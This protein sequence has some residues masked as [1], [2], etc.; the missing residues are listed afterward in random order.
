MFDLPV[1]SVMVRR[2]TLKAPPATSIARAA[3]LMAGKNVGA[4]MVV[5]NRRLVGI[6]TER[7]LV[8]RVVACGL[9]VNTTTLSEVMTGEPITIDPGRSFGHAMTL[10]HEKGF[11]HLPVVENGMPIGI[12]SAR[13][14]M[15][16]DLE[17]FVS[18]AHRREHYRLDR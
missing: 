2:K 15:D 3:K 4:I 1:R 5:A 8:F 9:D 6:F 17:D 12:V 18:E 13:S 11:R 14:A 16:P 7:D 10:M